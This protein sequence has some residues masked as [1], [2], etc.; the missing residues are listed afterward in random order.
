[1]PD[2]QAEI[3]TLKAWINTLKTADEALRL[4]GANYEHRENL[5]KMQHYLNSKLKEAGAVK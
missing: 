2:K 5:R 3:K 1:M 4:A